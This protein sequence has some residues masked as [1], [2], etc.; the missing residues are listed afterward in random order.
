MT[1]R[2]LTDDLAARLAQ[3]TPERRA[4]VE[5]VLRQS[6]ASASGSSAPAARC[7]R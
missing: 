1:E 5:R 4:L 7:T 6:A 2:V 3:L